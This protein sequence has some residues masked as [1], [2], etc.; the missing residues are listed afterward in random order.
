MTISGT[1][2]TSGATINHSSGVTFNGTSVSIGST[3]KTV[4]VEWHLVGHLHGAEHVPT[5]PRPLLA[6][7][8]SGASASTTFRY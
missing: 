5:A 1:G 2:F 7:D 3:N 8:S 6:T 4:A